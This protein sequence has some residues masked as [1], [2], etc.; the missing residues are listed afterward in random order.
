[1]ACAITRSNQTTITFDIFITTCSSHLHTKN[2]WV[3][4]QLQECA[5]HSRHYF[6]MNI[7]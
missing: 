2:I 3:A 6:G 1:M 4:K 5:H 7:T